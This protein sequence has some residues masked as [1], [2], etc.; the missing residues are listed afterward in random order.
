MIV[1]AS[2]AAQAAAEHTDCVL[3]EVRYSLDPAPETVAP[4]PVIRV[5]MRQPDGGFS[6]LWLADAPVALGSWKAIRYAHD[7]DLLMGAMDL[8]PAVP[9]RGI[10]AEIADAYGMIT[11]CVAATGHAHLLRLWNFFPGIH[12]RESGL[13]RYQQFCRGRHQPLLA[14]CRRF[15]DNFPAA[16]A[17]GCGD[18]GGMLF[19]LASRRPG[20]HYENPRQTSAFRYPPQ[21]GPQSPSFA[22]A[23]LAGDSPPVLLISG[24]ASITGHESRHVGD[25]LAQFS[26]AL[27]NVDTVIRIAGEA[28]GEA[29]R[30]LQDL[31]ATKIYLRS[32][33]QRHRVREA[34]RAAWGE[35]PTLLVVGDLCR[36]ELLLEIEGIA[37]PARSP[38]PRHGYAIK[39]P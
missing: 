4:H 13:D 14:H 3:A 21:Y 20:R 5:P 18:A 35:V 32:E 24:T 17:I 28:S 26:E 37:A 11:N 15:R 7:E 23:T 34:A 39:T 36:S 25:A 9:G 16:T 2:D 22:R 6:E 10:E 38:E 33:A 12:R 8:P 1:P 31:R 19:F 29:L 30:G 27:Q